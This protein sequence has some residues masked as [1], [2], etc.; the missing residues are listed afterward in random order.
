ME[1]TVNHPA[2]PGV[3]AR[4]VALIAATPL[5]A[6]AAA[7]LFDPAHL[8]EAINRHGVLH[9]PAAGLVLAALPPLELL[10]AGLLV[11]GRL[12]PGVKWMT[13]GLYMAF[14]GYH[15]A[16]LAGGGASDCGCFGEFA[17]IPIGVGSITV[18]SL[19]AAAVAAVPAVA[20]EREDGLTLQPV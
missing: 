14:A 11:T 13:A 4:L 9:G 17:S 1:R 12:R 20:E 10:L 19:I 5:L 7:A 18:L 3:T 6:G 8:A 16:V 2:E 15:T